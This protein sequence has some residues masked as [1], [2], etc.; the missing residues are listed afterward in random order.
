MKRYYRRIASLLSGNYILPSPAHCEI[1]TTHLLST[2]RPVNPATAPPAPPVQSV[3]FS[4]KRNFEV[5]K[6]LPP[7]TNS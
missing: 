5:F 4:T 2:M 7:K 6:A 3:A 1:S